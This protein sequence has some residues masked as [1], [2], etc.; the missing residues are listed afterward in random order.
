MPTAL[1]EAA[2][3]KVSGTYEIIDNAPVLKI[4]V[5]ALDLGFDHPQEKQMI[6]LTVDDLQGAIIGKEGHIED[7]ALTTVGPFSFEAHWYN[8]RRLNR[9]RFARYRNAGLASSC[10]GTAI[11]YTP[12]ARRKTT[13]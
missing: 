2:H 1:L 9:K 8:R 10:S 12:M 5:E 6:T 4:L 3:A 13:G 11:E 7:S